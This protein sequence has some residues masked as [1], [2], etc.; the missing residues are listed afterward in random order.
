MFRR[1]TIDAIEGRTMKGKVLIMPRRKSAARI[2]HAKHRVLVFC[3]V[4]VS[5][6]RERWT[7]LAPL[8]VCL[9]GLKDA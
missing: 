1:T 5:A 6:R 2:R 4:K 3:P 9:S 7:T 8:K